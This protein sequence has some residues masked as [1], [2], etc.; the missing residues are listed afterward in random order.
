MSQDDMGIIAEVVGKGSPL[1]AA[2]H[3]GKH[4]SNLGSNKTT[5]GSKKPSTAKQGPISRNIKPGLIIEDH[6]NDRNLLNMP[7]KTY[8]S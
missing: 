3:R 2:T 7:S 1:Q 8:Q 6:E 5:F 4:P